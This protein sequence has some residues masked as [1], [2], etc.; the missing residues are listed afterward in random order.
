VPTY[1]NLLFLVIQICST[2]AVLWTGTESRRA[3]YAYS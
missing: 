1:F 2:M 3:Q